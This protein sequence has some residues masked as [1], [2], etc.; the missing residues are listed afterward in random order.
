MV[1]KGTGILLLAL[2]VLTSFI[3]KKSV[4]EVE[5]EKLILRNSKGKAMIHLGFEGDVP[6]ISFISEKGIS[7]LKLSG[8]SV[9][10]VLLSNDQG[11]VISTWTLLGDG[12][13]GIG[14]ADKDGGAAAILRGGDTPS[15]SFFAAQNE[16]VAALGV[17][18]EIP[19]LLIAGKTGSEGVLIHGGEPSSF[20][21][22]DE[23]G[24]VKILISKHG[25]YQGKQEKEKKDNKVFS[26]QDQ[27]Q[28]FPN[29]K[30]SL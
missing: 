11:K 18:K 13:G 23:G 27:A 21:V 1:K 7:S 17:V 9:P 25:V 22:L 8:G 29:D 12:G 5:A 30:R 4:N 3:T 16:P 15:A 20:L 26:F 24:K 10:G 6:Y 2:A 28:L 19:H 14:F